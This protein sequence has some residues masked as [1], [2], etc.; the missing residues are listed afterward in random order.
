MAIKPLPSVKIHLSSSGRG[1]IE[2]DGFDLAHC[3]QSV[4]IEASRDRTS[5]VLRLIPAEIELTADT[6][7]VVARYLER[8]A[9]Y[10]IVHEDDGA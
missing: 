9:A 10:E 7:L 1:S 6:A 5:V 8:P 2:V 4:S 3:V